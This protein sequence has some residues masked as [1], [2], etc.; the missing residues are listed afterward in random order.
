MDDPESTIPQIHSPGVPKNIPQIHHHSDSMV[1]VPLSDIQSNSEHTQP[2]WRTLDIPQTPIEV[3]SPTEES[4]NADDPTTRT[5]PTRD[6]D[7]PILQPH[8]YRSSIVS[9]SS[10]EI[11]RGDV[12]GVDWQEL[13]KSEEQ[14]PRGEGSDEVRIMRW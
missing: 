10:E 13:D 5:T 12:D 1:T 14:E 9:R 7:K 11:F 2:D 8:T 4:V 6:S 3:T